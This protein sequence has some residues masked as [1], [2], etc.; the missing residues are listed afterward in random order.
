MALRAVCQRVVRG[1]NV[2]Q[3]RMFH[4]G[5]SPATHNRDI[6]E[7]FSEMITNGPHPSMERINKFMNAV[8]YH[9]PRAVTLFN[10]NYRTQTERSTIRGL[11]ILN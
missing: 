11:Y 4:T 9:Q 8:Y 3:R 10:I 6:S 7:I 5:A 1:M 2:P